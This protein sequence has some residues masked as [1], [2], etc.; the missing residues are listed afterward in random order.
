VSALYDAVLQ[1]PDDLQLRHVLA[2][3]LQEAQDPR[4]EFIALQLAREHT[5]ERASLRERELL[6]ECGER[7]LGR[8]AGLVHQVRFERG[9]PHHVQLRRETELPAVVERLEEWATIGS[10]DCRN[11]DERI[12]TRLLGA[13]TFRALRDVS[14]LSMQAL[15]AIARSRGPMPWRHLA[16]RVHPALDALLRCPLPALT[17]LQCFDALSPQGLETLV[18]S[19]L[20]RQ[21]TALSFRL[22]SPSDLALVLTTVL[23]SSLQTVKGIS[24]GGEFAL[25]VDAR[26]LRAPKAFFEHHR[27]TLPGLNVVVT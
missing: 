2:D 26:T 18:G 7:W 13:P 24:S 20:G 4:G 23:A 17:S 10:V 6:A 12:E 15:T 9:F 27:I 5:G 11:L 1:R 16:V 8:L 3:A 21:L 22:A 14:G 25:E 19:T